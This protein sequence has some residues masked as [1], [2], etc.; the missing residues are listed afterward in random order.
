M[1]AIDRMYFKG[2]KPLFDDD[3]LSAVDDSLVAMEDHRLGM[4]G[5]KASSIEEAAEIARTMLRRAAETPRGAGL[6]GET[7]LNVWFREPTDMRRPHWE[8]WY[9][10]PFC[11][12][13]LVDG[14]PLPPITSGNPPFPVMPS[15]ALPPR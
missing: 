15:L 12:A 11:A 4:L 9:F 1:P 7:R 6:K 10:V 14:A 3:S 8:A 2:F 13:D 5:L